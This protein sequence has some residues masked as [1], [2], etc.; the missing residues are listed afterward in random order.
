M[1]E[2]TNTNENSRVMRA[3]V[4]TSPRGGCEIVRRYYLYQH[5]RMAASRI[6][7]KRSVLH[8]VTNEVP[9][10]SD[11]GRANSQKTVDGRGRRRELLVAHV[12][13]TLRFALTASGAACLGEPG[14]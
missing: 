13:I 7:A 11:A 10:E 8:I 4:G 1:P 2:P 6:R 14:A 12:H 5:F 9:A 3:I